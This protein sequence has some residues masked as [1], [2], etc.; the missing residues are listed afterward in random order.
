[1][2]DKPNVFLIVLNWNGIDLLEDCL[3]S[4]QKVTHNNYKTLLVDNC[5][6]DD[7]VEFV[8]S[9][10]PSVDILQLDKNYGFA[11]GNNLGCEHAKNNGA[12][13]VIFLNNDTLV[14]PNFIEPLI[15]FFADKA[16]GQTVPKIYYAEEREKI[17]YAGGKINFWTGNIY[18]E[19]I[20]QKDEEKYNIE[21]VTDYATGCCIAMRVADY[22]E[23]N[24][25][26][27]SFTM[28]GEDVDLSIRIKNRGQKV[29][30]VPNSKIYHKVSASIGGAF[31]LKKIKRKGL[32]NMKLMFMYSQPY[33]WLV[34]LICLPF[35]IL[36][37]IITFL[38]YRKNYHSSSE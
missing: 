27:E 11:R 8:K 15:S 10:F 4:L 17:W 2:T 30:F 3:S 13:Y 9:H 25:F 1:M 20:R 12:E 34:Q 35:L 33:Q 36:K 28:Y 37:G 31:S 16:V 21:K 7:S 32:A 22:A 5:S 29:I 24:G 18:H 23:I 19:G 6:T 38:R 26:D 14:D